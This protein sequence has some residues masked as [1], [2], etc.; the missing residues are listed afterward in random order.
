MLRGYN[1]YRAMEVGMKKRDLTILVSRGFLA[2]LSLLLLNDFL[3]K[4]L[5]HNWLTGKLSDFAGLFIFP[6]FWTVLFPRHKRAVYVLT[7]VLFAFWKSAYSQPLFDFCHEWLSLPISRTVDLT[8]L[9]A[10]SVLPASYAYGNGRRAL[11]PYRYVPH[12]V[13]CVSLFAFTATSYSH[14]MKYSGKEYA[15]T[16]TRAALV[17]KAVRIDER[18]DSFTFRAAHPDKPVENSAE[19][20]Y[21]DIRPG[22]CSSAVAEVRIADKSSG[23]VITLDEIR[24]HDSCRRAKGNE[25]RALQV[26]ERDFINALRVYMSPQ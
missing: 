8:D 18:D 7:A 3:L 9:I 19:E 12:F 10:L 13:G 23:S 14:R 6:L 1:D 20:F 16:E 4:P 24:Y 26:F 21:V 17:A 5:F 25:E 22:F 2:G 15:F 11:L